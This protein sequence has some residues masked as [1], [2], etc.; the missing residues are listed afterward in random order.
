MIF[1]FQVILC[2]DGSVPDKPKTSSYIP[3][4][5]KSNSITVPTIN[6]NNSNVNN[7]NIVD[8]NS[9]IKHLSVDSN[10]YFRR[11]FF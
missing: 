10:R 2:S 7:N 8:N 3:M 11:I 6:S 4:K 9:S 1:I 5:P